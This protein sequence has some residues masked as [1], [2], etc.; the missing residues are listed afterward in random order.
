MDAHAGIQLD[1]CTTLDGAPGGR[2]W[3]ATVPL[4]QGFL[5][6]SVVPPCMLG[7]RISGGG[8]GIG[9]KADTGMC[10]K[11]CTGIYTKA[12]IVCTK[13]YIIYRYRHY[14]LNRYMH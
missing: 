14:G 8:T 4:Y 11:A 9:T 5:P 6:P 12:Y 1:S 2:E 3:C 10:T 13:A 7:L